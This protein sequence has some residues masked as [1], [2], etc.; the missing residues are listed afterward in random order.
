[1]PKQLTKE[2]LESGSVQVSKIV[3]SASTPAGPDMVDVM[4][5]I[6]AAIQKMV[7]LQAMTKILIEKPI[8]QHDN[9]EILD[10]LAEIQF[11]TQQT[12]E[13]MGAAMV[14]AVKGFH[15]PVPVSKPR[16]IEMVV[17]ERDAW[18]RIKT[19]KANLEA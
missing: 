17:T 13:G 19:L 5:E 18:G 14:D 8:A 10:R 11:L 16:A 1:M 7:A 3:R 6:A 2:M 9:S 12:M 15:A 4:K